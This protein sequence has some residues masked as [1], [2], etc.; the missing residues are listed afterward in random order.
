MKFPITITLQEIRD[1]HPCKTGWEK[2]LSANGGV[3]ADM[4][5]SFELST[6]LESN[7]FDDCMWALRCKPE[8]KN[9][10]IKLAVV[11]A[12]EVSHLMS[13]ERTKTALDIAWQY[14]EGLVDQN[15]AADAAAYAADAA[16]RAAYAARAAADAAARAAR[17]A[18]YAY[19]AADAAAADAA[20]A[21]AAAAAAAADAAYA[22][23]IEILRN[24]LT[25]GEITRK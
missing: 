17:A 8:H 25:T 2:V 6:I 23:Q 4:N 15:A 14:S 22:K 20:Y 10:F 3:G 24:F 5:K 9:F 12:D 7:D 13:D 1:N 16:A 11:F 21:Y 19:A 18:T